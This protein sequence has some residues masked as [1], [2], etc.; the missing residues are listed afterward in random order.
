M[1]EWSNLT[2]VATQLGARRWITITTTS[3]RQNKKIF[4]AVDSQCL[5]INRLSITQSGMSFFC[6]MEFHRHC[7][8]PNWFWWRSLYVALECILL[9]R[10]GM[11]GIGKGWPGIPKTIKLLKQMLLWGVEGEKVLIRVPLASQCCYVRTSQEN[12]GD[13]TFAP[14][15]GTDHRISPWHWNEQSPSGSAGSNLGKFLHHSDWG[16]L[17]RHHANA[18][19]KMNQKWCMATGTVWLSRKSVKIFL[20]KWNVFQLMLQKA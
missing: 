7:G 4:G 5:L 16:A 10:R 1:A 15:Y 11:R 9:G 2:P 14:S 18:M 13:S 12:S 3:G 17:W 8:E 19:D 20:N 6:R